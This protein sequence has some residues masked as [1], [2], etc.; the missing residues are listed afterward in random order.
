MD[1]SIRL[2]VQSIIDERKN[3]I[4]SPASLD[5]LLRTVACGAKGKTLKQLLRLLGAKDIDELNSKASSIM[6]VLHLASPENNNQPP[7]KVLSKKRKRKS[8]DDDDNVSPIVSCANAIWIDKQYSAKDSFKKLVT[9]VYR[10]ETNHVDFLHQVKRRSC[11][12]NKFVAKESTNGLI[13][14]ILNPDEISNNTPLVLTNA[15]YFKAFWSHYDFEET[16]SRDTKDFHLI[17]RINKVSVPFMHEGH[18][19]FRYGKFDK[20][21]VLELPYETGRPYRQRDEGPCFS[22]YIFLPHEIDGLPGML[23][24]FS[25]S[26]PTKELSQ[27]L[28]GLQRTK[29]KKVVIPKWKSSHRFEAKESMKKLGL[30]LPFKSDQEDLT[31]MFIDSEG[32][33]VHISNVIQRAYID[34]NEKGTEA[35]AVSGI[36]VLMSCRASKPKPPKEEKF[37]ADH[38]FMF[39]IM[40]RNSKAVIFA[41]AVFNPLDQQ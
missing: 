27:T 30:K 23:S 31:E 13:N 7:A 34:V 19:W 4:V 21:K 38:P 25:G 32:K 14:N 5:I 36:R 17:D 26:K 20:F 28:G 24:K 1:F 11:E 10:A 8:G 41:G 22:M 2:A 37:I 3:V 29:M 12:R 6:K 16:S 15:I 40:E 18:A 33:N 39:M 35:A 9:N